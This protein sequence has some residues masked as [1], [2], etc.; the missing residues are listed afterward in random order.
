M[1]TSEVEVSTPALD[2]DCTRIAVRI[3]F[4]VDK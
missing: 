3:G 4:D 1:I 2:C